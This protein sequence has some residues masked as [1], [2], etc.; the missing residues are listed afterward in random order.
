VSHFAPTRGKAG[1]VWSIFGFTLTSPSNRTPVIQAPCN[2]SKTVTKLSTPRH[3]H[4]SP[5]SQ[6]TPKLID[7]NTLS[8]PPSK[9]QIQWFPLQRNDHRRS[10]SLLI[11]LQRNR[12]P[13]LITTTF[14]FESIWLD[15]ACTGSGFIELTGRDLLRESETVSLSY[16]ILEYEFYKT[17][18]FNTSDPQLY[19]P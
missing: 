6:S 12:F 3:Q 9:F 11:G 7:Q 15:Q 1:E 17:N 16:S 4:P 19:T 13:W 18:F 10:T 2:S 8:N 14:R 5:Q